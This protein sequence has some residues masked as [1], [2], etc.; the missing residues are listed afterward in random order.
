MYVKTPDRYRA[1]F[2]PCQIMRTRPEQRRPARTKE[3]L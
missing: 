1:H 2:S 3:K